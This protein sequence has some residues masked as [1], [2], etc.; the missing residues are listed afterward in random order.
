MVP[1]KCRGELIVKTWLMSLCA[2]LFPFAAV[3]EA[4]GQI[5]EPLRPF[6]LT[7]V[8]LLP[9]PCLDAREKNREYL[10][11]LDPDRLL[12]T[13]RINAGLQ[14]PGE[15]LGGWE[16]PGCEVRGHFAGHFLSACATMWAATGDEAL[17]RKAAYLVAE[18]AKCQAALG[19]EYLSAFPESLWDRL[20][21]KTNLPWAPYY[22]MHKIMT[23]LCDCYELCGDAQAL[24]VLKGMASYFKNR[25]DS[26]SPEDFG[27]IL[28]LTEEGGMCDVLWRLYGITGDPDHR[29]LAEKFEKR[30]FLDPLARCED[31]LTGR[32]GNTHI[33]L[34]IGAMRRFQHTGEKRYLSLAAFFWD[35]VVTARCFATGGTTNGEMWGEPF[36][37]AHT[38]SNSNHETCKTYNLLKLTRE[39]F[40]WTADT[41]YAEYYER[42]FFNGILGTQEPGTGMLEY[43]VPQA[44]GYKRVFG[45]PHDAFWCCYGTGIESF[46]K[47]GDSIY[48]HDAD[49][50]YVNLFIASE[51]TWS[52]KGAVVTQTATFPQAEDATFEIH[53]ENPATFRLSVR[54][55]AWVAQTPRAEINGE[56]VTFAA[57]PGTYWS[58]ER[59]W[60]SGDHLRLTLPMDLRTAP[61][62]D[63]PNLAAFLYGP[64]VLAGI[65]NGPN[66]DPILSSNPLE[67]QPQ[68]ESTPK[69]YFLSDSVDSLA[70]L[71]QD[72]ANALRFTA[73]E[74]AFPIE[75]RPFY[76]VVGEPYGLYWWI[77]PEGSDLHRQFESENEALAF[78]RTTQTGQTGI[79]VLRGTYARLKDDARLLGYT[80]RLTFA[81]ARALHAAG[82]N[83]EAAAIIE[84]LTRPF[85]RRDHAAQVFDIAGAPPFND[86]RPLLVTND[87]WD[88]S[89]KLTARD[90]RA[91]ITT[92]LA[93]R[94]GH[95]YFSLPGASALRGAGQ[96][97][98]IQVEYYAEGGPGR[99]FCIE[100]DGVDGPYTAA[101]E[102]QADA[103]KG[104][105]T[106]DVTCSKALFTGRQNMASDFRI[107]CM[108]SGDICIGD[109]AVSMP[110]EVLDAF[111]SPLDQ[112]VAG[113]LDRVLP[114]DDASERAH[115][116]QVERSA[117]GVHMGRGWRHAE[118]S[119]S[120]RLKTA[121]GRANQLVCAYW[122]DDIGR[123]FD[124]LVDGGVIAT[125]VLE[126]PDPGKF[127]RVAYPIPVEQT[128]DRSEIV[129]T[130]RNRRG[131]AG[132]V[133]LCVTAAP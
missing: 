58:V 78:L 21:T 13:F 38:L 63:A 116:L 52:E 54:I 75:F 95:I 31:N 132:G 9:G 19:G 48:F 18:L 29:V 82:E 36:K 47:I 56:P 32:H 45:K 71:Q 102:V 103:N 44:P 43:Y 97:A 14:A 80:D 111:F 77:V 68:A 104:W 5:R 101:G 70:F 85:I 76:Q 99:R 12:Y 115:S 100:Y 59:E 117:T 107:N 72:P 129:L 123:E 81:M 65:L 106:A 126:R 67:A 39:L 90:G 33:P 24:A 2:L 7:Q 131:F 94:K 35:R 133:F 27:K 61:M 10:L 3:S 119:W 124:I 73:K 127:F 34:V 50:L 87:A 84:P 88:G 69:I 53:V 114:G 62:P 110:P 89:H 128:Q 92:D 130:F 41:R 83:R 1:L 66:S 120:W 105:H 42:A 23:G 26:F 98:R 25:T 17:K 64:V 112:P 49:T 6:P 22:T 20:E 37:L 108:G 121:P 74:Q 46:S 30:S 60:H 96:D 125:Q 4:V 11:S 109:V 86:V 93:A 118:G 51:V 55:P 8:R 16:A 79:E 40:C 28:D 15:P 122:G 57:R 91:A 113:E